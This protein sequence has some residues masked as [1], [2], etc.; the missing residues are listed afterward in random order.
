MRVLL[1][2]PTPGHPDQS[3]STIQK[4]GRMSAEVPRVCAYVFICTS[5]SDC[6]DQSQHSLAYWNRDECVYVCVCVCV[7]HTPNIVSL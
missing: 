2:T 4:T 5:A 1:K 3:I 6:A 7:R